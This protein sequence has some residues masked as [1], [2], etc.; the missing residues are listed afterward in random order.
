MSVQ[1]DYSRYLSQG[2]TL[3]EAAYA[4]V[5]AEYEKYRAVPGNFLTEIQYYQYL[6]ATR[7]YVG[8]IVDSDIGKIIIEYLDLPNAIIFSRISKG[9]HTQSQ[10][11]WFVTKGK[12]IVIKFIQQGTSFKDYLVNA[13]WQDY[14]IAG[15][16]VAGVALTIAAGVKAG[17][18]ASDIPSDAP[19][20][21]T[22]VADENGT[23][24]VTYID[25]PKAQSARTW[26][27]IAMITGTVSASGIIGHGLY[28]LWKDETLDAFFSVIERDMIG[29]ETT[30]LKLKI[31]APN[32]H[33]WKIAEMKKNFI[34]NPPNWQQ[35]PELKKMVCPL[36]N[37][38][39]LFPVK[40]N[41]NPPHY[42]DFRS[43]RAYQLNPATTDPSE[44]PISLKKPN[45]GL[46]LMKFDKA[47]F[48]STQLTIRQQN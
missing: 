41:C 5:H 19:K 7:S 17:I 27:T 21:T 15:V 36:S 13:G 8:A 22:T 47:Q 11:T 1:T 3:T 25:H 38:F 10:Q 14:V 26:K 42:L 44:C 29:A 20:K 31:F 37:D 32:Y 34:S 45:R 24:E 23:Y 16:K 18:D 6:D 12:E 48:D 2:G 35:H 46:T 33:A 28:C 30:D 9:L 43:I 4:P 39:M 40:D